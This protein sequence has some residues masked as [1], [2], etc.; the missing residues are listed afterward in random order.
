MADNVRSPIGLAITSSTAPEEVPAIARRGED[1]GFG[2]I[3]LPEDYFFSGGIST[4]TAT[5]AATQSIPVGLGIVSAMVRHPGLLAMELA[6]VS[7]MY[8]GRLWPGIGLGVPYWLGQMG[9]MPKSSLAA[10]RECVISVR[11]LLAGDE[12]TESGNTFFFENVKLT[13]PTLE[14]L[15]IYMGVVGPKMLQLSGEIASG[16]VLGVTSSIEYVQWAREQITDGAVRAGRSEGHRVAC[17]VIFAVDRDSKAAKAAARNQV[18]FYLG[19]MGKSGY[20]DAYG[21]SEELLAMIGDHGLDGLESTIPDKWVED[22]SVSGD[23]DE[24]VAKIDRY[25]EAGADSVILWL[26]PTPESGARMRLAASEIL[27]RIA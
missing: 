13:H 24:C 16:T 7:R 14:T 23:P 18:A 21:I 3:W 6:T 8:P 17:F 15:P 27:P 1:L 19:V 4:A 5:L 10:M 25:R 11:R 22:L 9:L 12:L 2:E 26:P 20:S